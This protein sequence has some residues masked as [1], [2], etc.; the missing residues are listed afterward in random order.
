MQAPNYNSVVHLYQ[1]QTEIEEESLQLSTRKKY[2]VNAAA[3]YGRAGLHYEWLSLLSVKKR[4]LHLPG[5]IHIPSIGANGGRFGLINFIV[6][7][8]TLN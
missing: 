7:A 3:D 8:R 5:G 2:Y 1:Y 4:F 6:P